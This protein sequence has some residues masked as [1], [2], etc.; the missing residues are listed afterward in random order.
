MGKPTA[1]TPGPKVRRNHSGS[2]VQA[3]YEGWLRAEDGKRHRC[4]EGT[5]CLPG[6]MAA[7]TRRRY[8]WDAKT[9]SYSRTISAE[10]TRIV[11]VG[12][13]TVDHARPV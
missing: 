8:E 11:D 6:S 12:L 5:F 13:L 7:S 2:R 1:A 10:A 4:L 9:S 3:R